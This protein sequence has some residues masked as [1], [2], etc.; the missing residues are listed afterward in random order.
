MQAKTG[1][2]VKLVF[3]Q[4]IGAIL[5]SSTDPS[6]GGEGGGVF[7]AGKTPTNVIVPEPRKRPGRTGDG[8]S[9]L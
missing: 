5:S 1:T 7:S 4:L 6:K 8:C 2:N 3:D 9:I